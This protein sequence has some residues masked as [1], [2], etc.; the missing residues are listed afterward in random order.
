MPSEQTTQ[1]AKHIFDDLRGNAYYADP[2]TLGGF[3]KG[4][5]G[6]D[7]DGERRAVEVLRYL[8]QKY[9]PPCPTDTDITELEATLKRFRTL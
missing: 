2:T 9:V 7:E 8:L 4:A 1:V 6:T 5:Q 3:L